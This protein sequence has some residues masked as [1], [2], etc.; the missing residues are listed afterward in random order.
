[1][2][3]GDLGLEGGGQRSA[4]ADEMIAFGRA[5]E[6]SDKIWIAEYIDAGCIVQAR[7]SLSED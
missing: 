2:V 5:S 1:M 7:Q 3:S 4:I 6:V